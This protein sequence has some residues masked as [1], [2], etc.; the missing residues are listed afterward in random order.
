VPWVTLLGAVAVRF[1]AFTDSRGQKTGTQVVDVG[2]TSGELI[3]FFAEASKDVV[4]DTS[5]LTGIL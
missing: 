1:S 3:L 5:C 4:M 2:Q